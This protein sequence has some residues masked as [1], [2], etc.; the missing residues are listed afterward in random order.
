MATH[1]PHSTLT[2]ATMKLVMTSSEVRARQQRRPEAIVP[3][4]HVNPTMCLAITA[5]GCRQA[6]LAKPH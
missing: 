6:L 3:A 2:N 5:A 4:G 1:D